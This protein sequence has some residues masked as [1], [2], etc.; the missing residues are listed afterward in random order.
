M[1]H[2]LRY[3]SLVTLCV[4]SGWLAKYSNNI[5]PWITFLVSLSAYIATDVFFSRK[6]KS[7]LTQIPD[8]QLFHQLSS[9]LSENGMI[10]YLMDHDIAS[11]FEPNITSPLQDFIHNWNDPQH[12]FHDRKLN[13][14]LNQLLVNISE[15]LIEF[16]YKTYPDHRNY[17]KVPDEW[18]ENGKEKQY[19][20][21]VKTL[22]KLSD[23]IVLSYNKL[24]ALAK[25]R[26]LL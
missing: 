14:Q 20:A 13:K 8:R 5:E 26:L 6:K 19:W 12:T 4:S 11:G 1:L 25:K 17:Q 22:N 21:T 9:L 16:A 2:I 15:F 7:E 18:I 23:D 10:H 3:I 24:S